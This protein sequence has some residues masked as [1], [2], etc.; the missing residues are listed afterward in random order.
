MIEGIKNSTKAKMQKS[1]EILE[2]E[3]SKLR[4]GRAHPSI[5]QNIMVNYYNTDTP[6]N[7]VANISVEDARTLAI[8][9]WDKKTIPLVEKAILKSD[10][11]LNPTTAGEVVRVCIPPLTEQRR[12]EL[13]KVVKEEGE[14]AKV[15]IRNVRRE[16][17]DQSKALVKN[18]TISEDDERRAHAE[19]QKITDQFIEK[20]DKILAAK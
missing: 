14:K 17:N 2:N 12:R 5:L 8:S 18:K 13:V 19:V 16:A 9:P 10:L 15:S 20:A 6:L 4:T 11:G 7:Q 3:L 1:I